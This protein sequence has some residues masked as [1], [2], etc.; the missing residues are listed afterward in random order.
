VAQI[1]PTAV[2]PPV[3][4]A[5][6][7]E[8]FWFAVKL[9]CAI[10]VCRAPVTRVELDGV[11]VT[12]IPVVSVTIAFAEMFGLALLLART[13]TELPGGREAGAVYTVL[14]GSVCEFKIVPTCEFPPTTP[15][16]SQLTVVSNVP[17]TCA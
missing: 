6:V 9:A 11:S 15:F 14:L 8:K 10:S 2:F 1:C 3:T 4:P 17:V 5:T 7:Q 12:L 13:V 16:T